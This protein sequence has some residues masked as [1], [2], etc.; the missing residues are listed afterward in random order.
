VDTAGLVF[1]LAATAGCSGGGEVT[2]TAGP[3]E[4]GFTDATTTVCAGS[5]SVPDEVSSEDAGGGE[6]VGEA[7]VVG[8]VDDDVFA[9]GAEGFDGI[10][11][12]G[13]GF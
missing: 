12:S 2:A 8:V 9:S 6:G 7:A 10:S 5:F 1:A 4:R 11:N 13:G 3:L